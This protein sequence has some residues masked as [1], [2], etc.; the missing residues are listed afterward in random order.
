MPKRPTWLGGKKEEPGPKVIT[1]KDKMEQMRALS[2]NAK[3]MTPELQQRVSE[4]LAQGIAHEQDP[5]LR[6]QVLRTL[7][8]F[9]NE[10]S[11]AMLAAG[12]HDH[13]RD[14]RIAACEGLGRHGGPLAATE[15]ARVLAED[16]DMDVRLA[17][18]RALGEAKANASLPA[19][20]DALEDQ[21]PALQHRAMASIKQISGKDFGNDIGAYR[22]FAKS[23]QAPEQPSFIARIFKRFQ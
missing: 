12:L 17:A 13:E 15:L 22:E 10:K 5:V 19:L 20:G 7:G 9:P 6:A 16:A 21:D 23:G 14:V 11:G 1:P 8:H 3:K 2:D 4:E 18:A